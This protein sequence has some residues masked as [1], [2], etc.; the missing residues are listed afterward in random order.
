M[1]QLLNRSYPGTPGTS[2]YIGVNP[3]AVGA[4]LTTITLN[5]T[6]ATTQPS[7]FVSP[8]FGVPFAQG[9]VAAGTYPQFKLADGTPCPTTIW[10]VSSWPDGSMKF[11]GAMVRVPTSVPGSGSLAIEVHSAGSA[12]AASARGTSDL[13]AADLKVELT[14]VTN[15]TGVWT[16]SLNT[17]IADATDVVVIGDGPAGKI[18]RIGG[19]CKQSGA[20]HGQIHAWHYV[21]A[22]TNSAGNLLGL[23]YLGRIQQPW[24][25]VAS[26]TPARRVA[27]VALKSGATT[28]RALDGYDATETVGANI[29]FSHYGGF[30][31]AGTEGKWDFV[32][33]GGSAVADCTLRVTHNKTHLSKSRLIPPYSLSET[34]TNEA[35]VD[36]RPN[37]QG[38]YETRNLDST[39][40]SNFIGVLPRWAIT[41]FMTQ[42]EVDERAVR[43]SALVSAA[44][45]V[46]GRVSATKQIV[47]AVDVKAT[48][49]GLGTIQTGWM[50]GGGYYSG[51]Q[52]P[53]GDSSLWS[54]DMNPSHRPNPHFYAYLITGEPQFL[55]LGVEQAAT[56][57][58]ATGPGTYTRNVGTAISNLRSGQYT[59][60]RNTQVGV[61][62]TTYK[63]AG[64][65]YFSGGV[66]I[67]AWL[68]RD[69]AQTLALLPDQPADG[70]D[71]K[72]Y[73]TDVL[74]SAYASANDLNAKM[75]QSW[76]DAGL[77]MT[78]AESA[79]D[80]TDD[81]LYESPWMTMYLSISLCHQSQ[82]TGIADATTLRQHL[83]KFISATHAQMDIAQMS[84]YRWRQWKGDG[85]LVD[86]IGEVLF[87]CSGTLTFDAALDTATLSGT[88][89]AWTPTNNDKFAFTT[90]L[91][92]YIPFAGASAGQTVYAVNASGK[93]LQ[94]A[95]T[96]GGSPVDIPTG[97][98]T[99]AFFAQVQNA[100]PMMSFV[101]GDYY[102][103]LVYEA[104]RF[105]EAC[106]DTNVVGARTKI[107]SLAAG[108]G[109]SFTSDPRSAMT[110]SYPG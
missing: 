65:L 103:K 60:F 108:I 51:V 12:P 79:S 97:G 1:A 84:S 28:I 93:T 30:F 46:G 37:A 72:G 11:C 73:F 31:T 55:D 25:D 53:A 86:S 91:A 85:T 7:G 109:V 36:Y 41:H 66:R 24:L 39:G 9:Q 106:G 2:L 3:P 101:D 102:I 6:S 59:G 32:Q 50:F 88:L 81:A 52:Q 42:S 29:G 100:A 71:V 27:T 83:S 74:T 26:P 44:F 8:M 77:F 92:P 63:G 49:A 58:T 69:I 98:A 22:L 82:I 107:D 4:L 16:A 57:I 43:V 70:A 13:I 110:N 67:S 47:P 89:G 80:R 99:S 96:L 61:G 54:G 62:G 87:M 38:A 33:G 17:A 19:P 20:D 75:P 45:R 21:A 10:G 64:V 35:S 14:G 68:T 18:W 94:L 104:A 90:N 40:P 15:L 5:N 78:N 105:H 48:Y 95:S 56:N 23:R 34:P 76:R